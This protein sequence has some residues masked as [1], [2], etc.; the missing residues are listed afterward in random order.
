MHRTDDADPLALL[1]TSDPG[2]RSS[3]LVCSAAAAGGGFK[4]SRPV[5]GP[6]LGEIKPTRARRLTNRQTATRSSCVFQNPPR[7]P[8]S[9]GDGR[10]CRSEALE[11]EMHGRVLSLILGSAIIIE[12][13]T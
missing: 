2:G 13:E 5:V 9:F 7:G 4:R 11:L 6:G 1:E 10:K 12:I 3:L 8:R